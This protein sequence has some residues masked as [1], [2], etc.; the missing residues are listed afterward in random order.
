MP[1][2]QGERSVSRRILAACLSLPS[3]TLAALII[4]ALYHSV[5]R[6]WMKRTGFKVGALEW[7]RQ[8]VPFYANPHSDPWLSWW[9]VPALVIAV[10]FLLLIRRLYLRGALRPALLLPVTMVFFVA[11]S[12]SVAMIDGTH[13]EKGGKIPAL[14]SPYTRVRYEYYG[15]APKVATNGLVAFLGNYAKPAFFKTLSGHAQTH[16]PGGSV[17]QWLAS[18]PFGHNLW[19][20]AVFTILFTATAILPVFLLARLL[21]GD[22]IARWSLALFPLV[23]SFQLFT[24]TCM[25]G[26]FSV[27]PIWTIYL[28]HKA[29][30]S[31][32]KLPWA[33]LTGIAMAAGMFMSYTSFFIGLFFA[34]TLA[35]T[36]LLDRRRFA[37]MLTVLIVAATVFAI[38]YVLLFLT[39]DFSIIDALNAAVNKD[40]SMMGKHGTSPDQYLN[41]GMAN[42]AAF[43]AGVGFSLA[44]AWWKECTASLRACVTGRSV[45]DIYVLAFPVALLTISYANLFHSEVERIWIFMVPFL[46]IPAAKYLHN[47]CSSRASLLPFYWVAITM[48]VQLL[49][50]EAILKFP[51]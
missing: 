24:S 15:D 38:C 4:F 26:P 5:L 6:A 9:L 33:I 21:Y 20:A 51:W 47:L 2:Q 29:M 17:F 25:D 43:L 11:I 1:G 19:S 46:V 42:L 10:L 30:A 48:A 16:P 14:L 50:M 8:Y 40:H 49:A 22:T 27:F 7:R 34:V 23:P 41:M 28:F 37:E 32:R 31:P 35:F 18:L 44:V 12:A 39:T 3:L 45:C 13:T 36:L